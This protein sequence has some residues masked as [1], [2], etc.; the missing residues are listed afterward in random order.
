MLDDATQSPDALL[1]SSD[2]MLISSLKGGAAACGRRLAALSDLA[3]AQRACASE[4]VRVAIIDLRLPGLDIGAL[5]RELRA[6]RDSTLEI[7]ACAPHVHTAS[8]SAAREAGCDHV[9]SRGQIEREVYT[10][11]ERVFGRREDGKSGRTI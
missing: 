10:L 5:V 8:L 1:L 7:V 11:F 2:L 6:S 3:G 9:V 4:E